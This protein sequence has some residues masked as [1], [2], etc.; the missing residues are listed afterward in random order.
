MLIK[1]ISYTLLAKAILIGLIWYVCYS[2]P[3][4]KHLTPK[5]YMAHFV[6][7]DSQLPSGDKA[8]T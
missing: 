3:V 7:T 2:D 1:E 6:T 4:S 8:A 5:T